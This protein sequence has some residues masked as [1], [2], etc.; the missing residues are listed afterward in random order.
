MAA[1]INSLNNFRVIQW[2]K[3]KDKAQRGRQKLFIAEGWHLVSAA[4]KA[5]A[6]AE[7]VTTEKS[8][9]F[10]VPAWQV[11]HD[12][13]EKLSSL[14]T[15]S[16]I[17]GICR[18]KEPAGYEDNILLVDQIHHPGNLGTIIRCAAAFGV[19]TVAVDNSADIY[20]QKV[21]QSTQGTIFSVNIIKTPLKEF[22]I[23]LKKQNYQIVG[24]DVRGGAALGAVVPAKKRALLVGNEAEGVGAGLK[25]MCD[26][27]VRIA[28]D[29][30]C[31]SLNVGVAAGII[32]HY[33]YIGASRMQTAHKHA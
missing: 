31:E 1:V 21:I 16:K 27:S 7:V 4:A 33:F 8:A 29:E 26:V 19:D 22:I 10:D 32:L 11:T 23:E 25:E 13:M 28:M 24:T 2:H 30:A 15:P 20:N 17:L 3:L 9:G 12:V 6:L 5:G 14:A 18:Q